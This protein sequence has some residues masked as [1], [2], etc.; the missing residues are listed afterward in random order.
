VIRRR[1][2]ILIG[3][4]SV[5]C[6]GAAVVLQVVRDR[7][8]PREAAQ[9]RALLYVRS[10]PALRRIALSFDDVAADVYWIR[11]IQHYGGDRLSRTSGRKY[12]LLYPLLD[13]TT[14]LDPYFTI[15]Y[16]FGAIFLSEAYPGGAGR[17]DQA[18]SL[19]RKGIAAQPAKW[20]YYH[21]IAFVYYWQLRDMESA[22]KWFRLAASQPGAPN[23][24]EPVA[25]SMLIQGGDRASARFLLQQILG[26]EEAWLRRMATR[27][28]MQV[29]ALDAIDELQ[30][31]VRANPPP[32]GEPYSW[33]WLVRSRTLPGIPLDPM[34]TPFDIDPISGA[35]SV[36]S[37]SDLSP[38][39]TRRSAQ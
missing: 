16:R 21:D 31:I 25:V 38:M 6:L 27:G 30:R 13:L 24:L 23:W 1:D 5:A 8:Y 2:V 28:L 33:Q 39:P 15:A 34:R 35:V 14:S 17:P 7:H 4:A 10:G 20:Q 12:E 22:A 19:L 36:S 11:A 26:S 9:A 29:D 32:A 37:G 18:I 3:L